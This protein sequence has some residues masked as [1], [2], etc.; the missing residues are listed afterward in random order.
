MSGPGPAGPAEATMTA[1]SALA[2]PITDE[3]SA[4]FWAGTRR[5]EL[6]LQ[7]CRACGQVRFPPMPRCPNCGSPDAASELAEPAGAVYSWITVHREMSGIKPDELPRTFVV[8][9]LTAGCRMVGRFAG[10]WAGRIGDPVV[11]VPLDHED[12]T[13]IR[14]AAADPSGADS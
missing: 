5:H 9:D 11:A 10:L 8:V 2:G 4:N 14:F 6:R 7:R 1:T 3:D 13:E 12:W